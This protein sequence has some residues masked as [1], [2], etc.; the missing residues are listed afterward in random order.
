MRPG[1]FTVQVERDGRHFKV[2]F[3]DRNPPLMQPS[4]VL[5][6]LRVVSDGNQAQDLGERLVLGFHLEDIVQELGIPLDDEALDAEGNL[7][8]FHGDVLPSGDLA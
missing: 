4:H 8:A 7:K 2:T 6:S 1:R 5:G 3:M